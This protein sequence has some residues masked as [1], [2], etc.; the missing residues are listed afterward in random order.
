MPSMN[1][2]HPSVPSLPSTP[3]GRLS[4]DN[5]MEFRNIPH[6]ILTLTTAGII[7]V[8]LR[9]EAFAAVQKRGIMWAAQSAILFFFLPIAKAIRKK[10]K[11]V[12]RWYEI[13]LNGFLH[14][15]R[16][17]AIS[18]LPLHFRFYLPHSHAAAASTT[19]TDIRKTDSR[20]YFLLLLFFLSGIENIFPLSLVQ[21]LFSF[22]IIL[23]FVV[24]NS[25]QAT[26]VTKYRLCKR[27]TAFIT[28]HANN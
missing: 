3:P 12:T 25:S 28:I 26:V 17:L 19:T 21:I 18:S 9:E 11:K 13:R 10:K 4:E 5:T 16:Q 6:P 15:C 7:M 27:I 2:Q 23:R 1:C 22:C 20:A 24:S 8:F 14:P